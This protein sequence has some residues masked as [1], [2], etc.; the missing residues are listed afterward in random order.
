MLLVGTATQLSASYVSGS[1]ATSTMSAP[2]SARSILN[3]PGVASAQDVPDEKYSEAASSTGDDT[4]RVHTTDVPSVTA[5]LSSERRST[6]VKAESK[7]GTA[8]TSALILAIVDSM[9]RCSTRWQKPS[10]PGSRDGSTPASFSSVSRN[11][12]NAHS[13]SVPP[14]TPRNHFSPMLSARLRL[15]WCHSPIP[16]LCI[17]ISDPWL[18]GWQLLSCSVPSVV[19]RT[20]A[21]IRLEATFG[22][23]RSRFRQFQAGRMDVK[24]HGS[25]PKVERLG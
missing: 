22:A 11:S 20:C 24:M 3:L 17:H 12:A 21:K 7:L 9:V 25:G 13:L 15:T 8:S 23:I 5:K 1:D 6:G 4:Y 19:A 14:C 16:P 2:L 10:G 18:K